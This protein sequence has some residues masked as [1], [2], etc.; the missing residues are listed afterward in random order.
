MVEKVALIG[1]NGHQEKSFSTL[2]NKQK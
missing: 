1:A 2:I